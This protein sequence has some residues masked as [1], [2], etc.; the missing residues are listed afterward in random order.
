[1][2]R[3]RAVACWGTNGE[4]QVARIRGLYVRAILRQDISWFDLQ[5]RG[6]TAALVNDVLMTLQVRECGRWG[7]T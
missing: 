5:S 7:D 4:R 3:G 6:Q 1:M 2:A